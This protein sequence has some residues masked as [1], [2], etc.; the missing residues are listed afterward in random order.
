MLVGGILV[1][2]LI[3]LSKW[4]QELPLFQKISRSCVAQLL[5]EVCRRT[6]VTEL[7]CYLS[8]LLIFWEDFYVS[9]IENY[10]N[11]TVYTRKIVEI[12]SSTSKSFFAESTD[13]SCARMTK[14]RLRLNHNRVML[15]SQVIVTLADTSWGQFWK[16]FSCFTV[17]ES[18]SVL[19]WT[20]H[21]YPAFSYFSLQS[22][23]GLKMTVDA[24][25]SFFFTVINTY[26]NALKMLK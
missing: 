22:L 21:Y 6:W 8:R 5:A 16:S 13:S 26:E 15:P 1:R 23:L 17:G 2:Y 4:G 18:W 19:V 20:R 25:L 3:Q 7:K 9:E 11:A 14:R 10:G 12:G 24:F